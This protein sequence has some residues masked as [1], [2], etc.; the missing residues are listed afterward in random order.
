MK[1]VS[2]SI[3]LVALGVKVLTTRR[4][5]AGGI[6]LEVEGEDKATL[7]AERVR[8]MVVDG[9]RVRQPESLT[10]VLLLDV[11]EWADK[12][13]IVNGLLKAGIDVGDTARAT[14]STWKNAG[15][16]GGYVARVS[17]P[18][19]EAIKLAEA[20]A[21][22]VGWTRC[23]VKPIEKAQPVCFRCQE[24]GHLAAEC[25]NPAKER[26]CH[27][28]GAVDHIVRDCGQSRQ[29]EATAEQGATQTEN[30]GA[31]ADRGAVQAKTGILPPV[32]PEAGELVRRVAA[33]AQS[34]GVK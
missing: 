9:A 5:R 28:C 22:T 29:P 30:E 20:R 13:D 6:L 27:G 1:K 32:D 14:V 26:R 19:K 31:Q 23:K 17:L 34:D 24:R 3:D 2:Q 7:L 15:G 8:V 12:E 25:K 11:P 33:T 18:F 10:P 21:V 16:R 4:T